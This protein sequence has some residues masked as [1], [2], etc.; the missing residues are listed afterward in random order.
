MTKPSWTD[1]PE[2]ADYLAQDAD[3]KWYWYEN[4][5]D[6]SNRLASWSPSFGLWD[7]AELRNPNWRSTLEQRS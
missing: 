2:W 3:G 4:E 6:D 7:K 5:P 1:A